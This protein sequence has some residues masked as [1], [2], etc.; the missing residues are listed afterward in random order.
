MY[1][2][3]I[4]HI[5]LLLNM[6]FTASTALQIH[7]ISKLIVIADVHADIQRFKNILY[8]AK[9]I[10]TDNKWIAEPNTVV[11]QLGDQID[12]KYPVDNSHHFSMIYFTDTLKQLAA[13]KDS[14]FISMVGN[15]EL[16]NIEK[17]KR[18][19]SLQHIIASRPIIQKLDS[20]IFCHG[21]F[22][23]YHYHILDIHNKTFDDVNA[24]W[25]R[26]VQNI[27]QPTQ[28][29]NI[30]LQTLILDT[31]NSILYERTPDIKYDI[32]KLFDILNIDYMFVGHTI[33]DYVHLKDKIWYLDMLL[34]D[35]F[36][37]LTY[38]YIIIKDGDII[39]KRIDSSNIWY[40]FFGQMSEI[41]G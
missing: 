8:D 3:F 25:S 5:L 14:V 38:T 37:K 1:V 6:L 28:D 16:M 39:V 20:Y 31:E 18:K 33:T 23:K 29:D 32:N 27:P 30:I 40:L 35:A 34:K 11:I 36:E 17:I 26:Y 41:D 2:S 12:P 9:V 19:P 7:N 24:I 10:D 4:K 15:H 21:M 13:E 22:N